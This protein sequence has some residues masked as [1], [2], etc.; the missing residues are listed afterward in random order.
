MKI[1]LISSGYGGI[2]DHFESWIIGELTKKHE[3]AFFQIKSGLRSL[4][5]IT[6]TFN[7]DLALTLVGFKIPIHFHHWFK[8]QKIKTAVWFTEDPYY[9][10]QTSQLAQFYD[11]V[12]TIDSAAVE[13]YQK[14]GHTQVYQLPLATQPDIFK[15]EEVSDRYKSDICFV[16]YPYPERIQYIQLLLQKTPYKI[17][18]I[19]KWKRF[20]YPHIRNANLTIHEGWV[21]P[22]IAA[23]YYNG[24]KIVLNSHRPYNLKQNQNRIG[25]E[26]KTINNRTFDVAACGAFQLVDFKEDLPKFFIENEEMVTYRNNE[27]LVN[28]MIYYMENEIERKRIAANARNRV[29]KEHTF[30]QRLNQLLDIISGS[31]SNT[32]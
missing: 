22:S 17:F 31:F 3:V 7:P 30:E 9:M 29:L 10:D 24:A 28:K 18:L 14:N 12:F 4:Q 15:R 11:F 21:E 32:G 5:Y 23:N 26:G 8:Q 1:L 25:I 2:Y 13:Y 19:G 20:I 6:R 27:E 16:G